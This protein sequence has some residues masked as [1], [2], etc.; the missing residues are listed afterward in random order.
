MMDSNFLQAYAD[1]CRS[2]ADRADQFTKRRLLDLAADYERRLPAAGRS[3]ATRVLKEPLN[4]DDRA[5]QI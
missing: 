3:A 2:L 5:K 4:I 1:L